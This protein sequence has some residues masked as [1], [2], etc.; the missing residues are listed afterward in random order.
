[1]VCLPVEVYGAL[2][3]TNADGV[4]ATWRWHTGDVRHTTRALYGRADLTL[5]SSKYAVQ[6]EAARLQARGVSGLSHSIEVGSLRARASFL[7][8]NVTVNIAA[9]LFAALRQFGPAGAALAGRYDVDHRRIGMVALSAEYDP[10]DWFV[11]IEGPPQAAA[12]AALNTGLNQLLFTVPDQSTA[13]IGVRWDAWTDIAFK[14]QV[15]R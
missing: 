1:M 9:P 6:A 5:F 13:S 11:A 10:G 4:D 14:L 7:G 2:P 3:M 8:A 15:A 12:G